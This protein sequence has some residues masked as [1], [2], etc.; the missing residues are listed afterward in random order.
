MT[1][2]ASTGCS[3]ASPR[4]CEPCRATGPSS[5]LASAVGFRNALVHQYTDVDDRQVVEH[6]EHL[7]DLEDFVREVARWVSSQD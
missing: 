5:A 7:S 6:L 1:A 3:H 4:T 2:S